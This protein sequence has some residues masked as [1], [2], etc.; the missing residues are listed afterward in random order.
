[1]NRL[2]A[3][4]LICLALAAGCG[5]DHT[6]P[7]ASSGAAATKTDGHDHG[8]GDGH[9]AHDHDHGPKEML[10]LVEVEGFE[11]SAVQNGKLTPGKDV[12]F[13]VEILGKNKPSAVRFWL[14]EENAAPDAKVPPEH[15]KD[16]IHHADLVVP[17]AAAPT[18]R[19]WVEIDRAGGGPVK[20]SFAPKLESR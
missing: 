18:M 9:D 5:D 14:G 6:A 7:A 15:V 17:T 3:T 12:S 16:N 4:L 2:D 20:A 11:V 13:D 8:H 10:G 19:L 1:M